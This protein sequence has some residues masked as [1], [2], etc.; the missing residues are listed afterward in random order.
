ML[1]KK[2]AEGFVGEILQPLSGVE[3]QPVERVPGLGIELNAP[4]DW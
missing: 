4:A 1:L 3:T 2:V